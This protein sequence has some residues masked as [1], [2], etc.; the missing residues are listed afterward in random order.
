MRLKTSKIISLSTM[1]LFFS[2]GQTSDA[3]NYSNNL[4]IYEDSKELLAKE[5]GNSKKSASK[6]SGDSKKSSSKK[7]G[8]S[9]KSAS[10]KSG[11]SKK[12]GSE[13]KQSNINKLENNQ[14]VMKKAAKERYK[15]W[16]KNKSK[17]KNKNKN[18]N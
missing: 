5:G 1:L 14:N 16:K 6:K 12:S 15:I 18:K 7:S 11:D 4:E 2:I 3:L 10:K 13:K 9:K 8:D 17:N